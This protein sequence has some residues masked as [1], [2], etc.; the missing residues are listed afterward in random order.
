MVQITDLNIV[1]MSQAFSEN[2]ETIE[3]YLSKPEMFAN[4]I[5][6]TDSIKDARIL[7]MAIGIF[8]F[9]YLLIFIVFAWSLYALIRYWSHIPNWAKVLS[10]LFLFV[11]PVF[12]LAIIYGT[13]DVDDD[14]YVRLGKKG[15]DKKSKD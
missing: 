12:S 14:V 2:R 5:T 13:I 15:K 3:L 7:G 9:V 8:I 4:T 1:S 10:I 6:E 11:F